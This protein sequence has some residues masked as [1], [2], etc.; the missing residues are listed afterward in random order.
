MASSKGKGSPRVILRIEPQLLDLIQA[1]IERSRLHRRTGQPHNV[2]TWLR[3]AAIDRLK[4]SARARRASTADLANLNA[5][6]DE[7]V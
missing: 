2:S 3:Q 5:F 1:E 7:G 4:H 6:P